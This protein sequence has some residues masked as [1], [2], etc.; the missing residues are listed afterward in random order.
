MRGKSYYSYVLLLSFLLLQACYEE[1]VENESPEDQSQPGV[2]ML[3]GI[4]VFEDLTGGFMLYTIKAD[5][6]NSFAPLVDLGDYE[7]VSFE[8]MDLHH[9]EINELGKIKVNK[10]YLLVATK[11]S[12][13]ETFSLFFTT[14]PLLRIQTDKGIPYEPKLES[15][16]QLAYANPD[17]EKQSTLF[18]ESHA[19][20]EIRG[21]SAN[22]FDK[23]SYGIE[24]WQNEFRVDR[25][26]P[27][28]GM[29]YC[30]DWILDAMYIDELR[31]RNKFSF[32][33]WNKMETMQEGNLQEKKRTGIKMEYVELFLNQRYYGLYC[34]GEKMD[35][36]LLD[37]SYAQDEAGGVFYKTYGW[38]EGSTTFRSYLNEPVL[39]MEWDGWE[40]IF[41]EDYFYWDPLSDM[42][43]LVT[44]AAD[45]A[46]GKR[47]DSVLDLQNA[48]NF[49]L[50][51]NLLKAWDNV[52]KNI[53]LARYTE[54]SKFFFLPWDL[55]ATM[56]RTWE[57]KDSNPYG[58][59]GN[60]LHERLISL[61]TMA[62]NETLSEMW[63]SYRASVLHRD[64]LVQD[65]EDHYLLLRKNG[66]MSRE[67][68]RWGLEIDI[69]YEY[70]YMVK[71]IE[72][73]L[74]VLD[75]HFQP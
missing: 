63:S 56:G 12:S 41:P 25:S 68:E 71:W 54:S 26:V 34:L 66:V 1:L 58:I 65:V 7:A 57:M 35:E 44:V 40:Q 45:D 64:A 29:A 55:E 72:E 60:G 19:G 74:L 70:N 39:S 31:M 18:F 32:E 75:G 50:F 27:L 53:F 51:L 21:M 43:K 4:P 2:L 69:D 5:S 17:P 6:M 46:F 62:Y 38:H 15:H 48:A 52:G 24:L 14:L 23:K 42:R 67:N 37:F 36:Q 33:I 49:Y 30:E 9:N 13:T 59:V 3:N 61:N 47:I 28:L 20:I 22:R 11:G 8:G 16:L 73:R 10:S